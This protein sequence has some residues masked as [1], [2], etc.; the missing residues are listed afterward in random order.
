ML[1]R[2]YAFGIAGVDRKAPGAG[3]LVLAGGIGL[4]QGQSI[5]SL[6]DLWQA[7]LLSS[8]SIRPLLLPTNQVQT[9]DLN[10]GQVTLQK[11][12]APALAASSVAPDDT[13]NRLL[14]FGGYD[15]EHETYAFWALDLATLAWTDLDAQLPKVEIGRAHV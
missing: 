9:L 12:T 10:T 14:A 7:K 2:S 11:P 13:R 8:G 1:F 15:Q 5:G 6:T 4:Q 3:R